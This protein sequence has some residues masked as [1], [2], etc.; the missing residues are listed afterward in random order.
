MGIIISSQ[1]LSI[2]FQ[3]DGTRDIV[4]EHTCILGRKYRIKYNAQ[5]KVDIDVQMQAR[6]PYLEFS[7]KNQ[8]LYNTLDRVLSGEDSA[9]IK[10]EYLTTEEIQKYL[11]E[12]FTKHTVAEK[13]YLLTSLIDILSDEQI[14]SM[15]EITQPEVDDIRARV[16]DLKDIQTKIELDDAKVSAVEVG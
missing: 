3:V 8:E 11:L 1:I 10:G 5:S 9:K 7:I 13:V 12:W 14:I 4:E 16:I 15:I 6:I 2:S